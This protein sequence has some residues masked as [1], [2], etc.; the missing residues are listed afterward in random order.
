MNFTKKNERKIWLSYRT[1]K[2]VGAVN[3]DTDAATA[4]TV[5]RANVNLTMI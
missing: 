4:S 5:E 3:A 1:W 2:L